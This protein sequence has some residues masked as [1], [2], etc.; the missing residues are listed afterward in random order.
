MQDYKNIFFIHLSEYRPEDGRNAGRNMLV[1]ILWI[2]NVINSEV[3]FVGYL[4]ILD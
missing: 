3:H 2:K 4:Y 1:R